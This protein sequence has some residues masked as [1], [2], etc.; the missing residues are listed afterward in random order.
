MSEASKTT[1]LFGLIYHQ[2]KKEPI[3]YCIYAIESFFEI[4]PVSL[5]I[6]EIILFQSMCINEIYSNY[7]GVS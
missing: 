1:R 5:G 6:Y 4:N 2:F 7:V 3:S